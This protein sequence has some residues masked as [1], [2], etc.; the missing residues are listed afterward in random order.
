VCMCVCVCVCVCVIPCMAV[1]HKDY[2]VTKML[3]LT[4]RLCV[5]IVCVRL[6]VFL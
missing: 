2:K 4:V 5:F 3:S 1:L 6:F